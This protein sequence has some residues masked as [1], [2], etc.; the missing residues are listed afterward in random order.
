MHSMQ[1]AGIAESDTDSAPYPGWRTVPCGPVS[2]RHNDTR[3]RL[4]RKGVCGAPPT[5]SPRRPTAYLRDA[6]HLLRT[7]RCG[8]A[9]DIPATPAARA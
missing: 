2:V 9:C 3:E 6:G 4:K 5:G 1:G 8:A 7:A